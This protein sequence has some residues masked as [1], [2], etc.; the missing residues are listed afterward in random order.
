MDWD[1][2]FRIGD[3]IVFSIANELNILFSLLFISRILKKAGTERKIGWIILFSGIPLV[4]LQI[5]N[6]LKYR[7]WWVCVLLL[8]MIIFLVLDFVWDYMLNLEFRKSKL[9]VVYIIFF[10]S[11]QIGMIG[12]AFSTGKIYGFITLITYFISLFVGLYSYRK[13]G[14]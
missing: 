14:Y 11:G 12:Y 7:D 9:A 13:T 8:P 10:Y 3:L 4:V 5:L 1:S 2:I 6:L